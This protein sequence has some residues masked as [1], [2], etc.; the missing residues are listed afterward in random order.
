MVTNEEP[1]ALS[2]LRIISPGMAS[3]IDKHLQVAR[4]EGAI[5]ELE[6]LWKAKDANGST[7]IGYEQGQYIVG[8]LDSLKA[9]KAH[10]TTKGDVRDISVPNKE[11][12]HE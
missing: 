2:D 3:I 10:L 4:I 11:G 8:R 9:Q 5:E 6:L 1:N 12:D 7:L